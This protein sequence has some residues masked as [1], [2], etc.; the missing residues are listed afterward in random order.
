MKLHTYTS[1]PSHLSCSKHSVHNSSNTGRLACPS[2]YHHYETACHCSL[3]DIPTWIYS[4]EGAPC[5]SCWETSKSKPGLSP[6]VSGPVDGSPVWK[7]SEGP[8]CPSARGYP[9]RA[10]DEV[11]VGSGHGSLA[12]FGWLRISRSLWWEREGA[13]HWIPWSWSNHFWLQCTLQQDLLWWTCPPTHLCN[14]SYSRLCSHHCPGV[15][16]PILPVWAAGD[17]LTPHSFTPTLDVGNDIM[18]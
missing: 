8:V 4:L 2:E 15:W 9:R 13:A 16:A 12:D 18:K 7:S 1:T 10:G 6:Q 3:S 5:S 14:S 11:L 17:L